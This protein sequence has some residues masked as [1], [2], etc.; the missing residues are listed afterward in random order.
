[1]RP[2]SEQPSA[3]LR[4]RRVVKAFGH[5]VPPPTTGAAPAAEIDDCRG[6]RAHLIA[7]RRSQADALIERMLAR[8]LVADPPRCLCAHTIDTLA[9]LARAR[10]D[11]GSR[12]G[13]SVPDRPDRW[14]D[15]EAE[16]AKIVAGVVASMNALGTE[17]RE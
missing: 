16:V 8:A 9:G 6:I 3:P 11:S 12:T 2:L 10:V 17:R 7:S 14:L 13:T 4:P 15:L 1:M 5:L